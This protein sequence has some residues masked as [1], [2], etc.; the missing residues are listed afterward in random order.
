MGSKHFL[1]IID[2]LGDLPIPRLGNKTPLE[3]AQ[4][5][6]MDRLAKNGATGLISV[7]GQGIRPNSDEAHLTLFGYQL[8]EDY[9]GRGPI[10]AAG[11]GIKLQKGDIAIRGNLASVDKELKVIDRRAGRIKNSRPFVDKLDGIEIE[12]IKFLVKPG[13]GHRLVVVMRGPGLSD[14]ISNSDVHYATEG[15]VVKDWEGKKVNTIKPLNNTPEAQF[16]ALV[17]EKFLKKAHQLMSKNPLNQKR[18]LKA[19]YIL[20]R[21]PGYFKSL[22]SFTKKWEISKA[23]CI[24]GAGLYKGLGALAGMEIVNVP[25]ATGQPD[26]NLK[27]K[28]AAAKESL[29]TN[30]FVFLHIKA[31]DIFGENGDPEGKK[32]F[33]EKIDQ[34]IDNLEVLKASIAI[35]ADHSTPCSLKDHSADPVPLLINGPGVKADQVEKFAESSTKN[36]SLGLIEGKVFMKTFMGF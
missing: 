27:N 20:T 26:T 3:A 19:N 35:T 14:Q 6:N 36:G 5:P 10:E 33:I 4:T 11:L 9:P 15:Q 24:A 13:T 32:S 12:G 23:V 2:G 30:D 31:T 22:Q 34:A 28:I 18:K 17:L 7:L 8:P 29:K 21:G 16:T 25:G 1:I